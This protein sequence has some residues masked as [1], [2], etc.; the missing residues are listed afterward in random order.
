[1]LEFSHVEMDIIYYYFQMYKP[2]ILQH[3]L[4][5][6]YLNLALVVSSHREMEKKDCWL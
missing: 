4:K 2:F 1:M 3:T 5:Y 6:N